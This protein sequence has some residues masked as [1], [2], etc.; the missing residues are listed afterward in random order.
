MKK[1]YTKPIITFESLAVSANVSAGCSLLGTNSAEY[2]CPVI[3]EE[4]GW[5][6]FSNYTICMITPQ[7]GDTICYDIPLANSHVFSS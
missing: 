1:S 4:A 5:T 7:P 3:D 6:I 2:V